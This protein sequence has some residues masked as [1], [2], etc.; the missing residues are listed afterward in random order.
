MDAEVWLANAELQQGDI[1]SAEKRL[2]ALK[3]SLDAAP[4]FDPEIGYYSAE[5]DIALKLGDSARVE[6]ALRPAIF[7]SEWALHSLDSEA[8]RR[9]WA[10][11]TRTAYCDAIRWKLHQ[12]DPKSALELWE[13][14]RA[15]DLRSSDG[16][17]GSASTGSHQP[18]PPR[19]QDAE[20]L[21]SP[22]EVTRDL[23]TTQNRTVAAYAV[24][25]DGIALWSYD[26]RGINFHWI[27]ISADR[28][29]TLA[30][31]L[32]RLCADPNSDLVALRASARELYDVLIAPLEA[33]LTSGRIIVFEPDDLLSSV[34]WEALIDRQGNYLL[35]RAPIVV[36]P[37]LYQT[38]RLR[39]SLPINEKSPALIVA[40]PSV[41]SESL[42]PLIDASEEASAVA[43]YFHA[44]REF[45]GNAATL[46]MI[47]E[48]ITGAE[49]FHFAGHAVRSPQR[50]GLLL[51]E[52]DPHSQRAQ[53][54]SAG[55]FAPGEIR[56]LQL[57]VLSACGTAA[58]SQANESA[59]QSLA[60]YLLSSG[61]PHVIASRW[62]VDSHETAEFMSDF[63]A[64]L[65]QGKSVAD[66]IYSA[67]LTLASR[68]ASRH[69]YYWAAFEL[70][71]AA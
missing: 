12:G 22:L 27:T 23:A 26:D 71:G 35:E 50:S 32:S 20:A 61:V 13:W 24:F 3:P 11:Q 30:A 6:A 69:P 14:Y 7:L 9:E 49:I 5:A 60:E 42:P 39:T 56:K 21:P 57:A 55:T 45:Q 10:E 44:P 31:R 33:Q 63:Y 62:N 1:E 17:P 54:L 15:A 40:V 4:S 53:I 68:P 52:L 41:P 46:K 18:I 2:A 67:R 36:A 58:G 19:L 47:R 65:F 70:Q 64:K 34:P 59:T 25:A 48:Q 28:V 51:S 66:A 38:R 16:Q 43:R 37:G 29:T 8:G